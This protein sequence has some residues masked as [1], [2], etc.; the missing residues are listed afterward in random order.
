MT[1]IPKKLK[2]AAHHVMNLLV[3]CRGLHLP[4]YF[5]LR[6]KFRYLVCGIAE[7][8]IAFVASNFLKHGNTVIDVG[9]NVGMTA[10]TFAKAVGKSGRVHAIEPERSNFSY[11]CAN[12]LSTPWVTPHRF[13][14]AKDSGTRELCLNPICGSGNSFFGDTL[15]DLQRVPCLT[16]DEF[17]E[18]EDI[19]KIDCIKIDVEGA[20]IEVL[21]GM[22]ETLKSFPDI[23]LLIELCPE[24]LERAGSCGRNLLELLTDLGFTS[25]VL[26]EVKGSF[27]LEFYPDLLDAIGSRTYIN[28]FCSKSPNP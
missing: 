2:P 5:S 9:A 16:F 27:Q 19:A 25:H 10:R 26:E 22:T 21:M 6:N 3:G 1:I 11:L 8:D 24:N 12:T 15:G 23:I 20:E 28:L 4:L 13:A 17:C 18:Q 14:F 7:P